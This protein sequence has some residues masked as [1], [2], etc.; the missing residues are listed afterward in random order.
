MDGTIIC[1]L[2]ANLNREVHMGKA[3][4]QR[5]LKRM[6]F[7]ARIARENPE[8]F[9]A[10][11]EKRV[12]SWLKDIQIRAGRLRSKKK[13][14]VKPAFEQIDEIMELLRYCGDE[15]YNEYAPQTWELLATECSRQFGIKVDRSF[16]HLRAEAI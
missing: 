16:Y 12:T 1:R 11:W 5:R 15:I 4:R 13:N 10:E 8:L 3:A 9:E 2:S 7:L 6:K 14:P